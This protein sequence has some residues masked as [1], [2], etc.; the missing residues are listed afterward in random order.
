VPDL[1]AIDCGGDAFVAA[2]ARA[3]DAGDA[4]APLDPR[5]PGPARDAQLAALRPGWVVGAD[6]ERSRL[7]GGDPVEAGDALVVATSGTTGE[8]R[9]VVLTHDAVAASAA[10]TSRR[11]D[12]DPIR[13]RWLACL[14]LAHMGGLAVVTRALLTGTPLTVHERFD[15]AD[16]ERAGRDGCTLTSLVPTALARID[17]HLF[18]AILVGGQAP[19]PD[20][21]PHVLATYGMTETGSGVVYEGEPLEGVEL[22][23]AD[24]GEIQVRAPMLLRAYRDGVDPTDGDGWFPT[25]DLGE[26]VDGRLTVHGRRGDLIITGGENVWPTAV[27]RVLVTHPQV[28]EVAVVGRPDPQWGQAVTA[29]VV[30]GDPSSPPTLDALRHHVKE[31]LP[32]HAAPRHLELVRALPRTT[33][34]K[35]RRSAV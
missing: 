15:A 34:G 32:A 18:R 25:D 8:P 4:V 16:V 6:G 24:D 13:D 3:W 19:P 31:V 21:P 5:L 17:P 28:A 1:V 33:S 35:V 27:E 26:L 7:E 12:V 14:P 29:V 10:A 11:L 9:G 2:L 22:R 23:I 30:P 20:R